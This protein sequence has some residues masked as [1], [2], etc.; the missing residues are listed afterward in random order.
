MMSKDNLKIKNP[1]FPDWWY[2]KVLSYAQKH[3]IEFADSNYAGIY[4]DEWIAKER[5]DVKK[6]FLMDFSPNEVIKL[7]IE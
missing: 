3:S 6:L 5:R 7:F 2:G 1:T 4:Q